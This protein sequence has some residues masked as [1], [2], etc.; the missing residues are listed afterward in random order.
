MKQ[1]YE[2]IT[3]IL[4]VPHFWEFITV[5]L[6]LEVHSLGFV[7]Y[8][9]WSYADNADCRSTSGYVFKVANG[10]MSWKS[11]RQSITTTSSTEAEYVAYSLATK[12]AIWLRR[13]LMDLKYDHA[14]VHRVLIY[15]DNKPSLLNF[16]SGTSFQDKTH[17]RPL[18]LCL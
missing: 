16:K 10:P 7:G 11:K 12:E 6:C 3:S 18:S 4:L 1:G 17:Q 9:D 8:S 13:V 15:G 5:Q 2:G 14:D